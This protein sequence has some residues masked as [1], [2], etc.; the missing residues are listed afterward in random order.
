MHNQPS[1]D[2]LKSLDALDRDLRTGKVGHEDLMDLQSQIEAS[3]MSGSTRDNALNVLCTA[4]HRSFSSV[5][6]PA[7]P[8][9]VVRVSV[10]GIPEREMQCPEV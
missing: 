3:S 5:V 9:P 6:E 10:R 7:R 2:V 1:D 8:V 4:F